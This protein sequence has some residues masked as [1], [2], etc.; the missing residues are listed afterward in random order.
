MSSK[1]NTMMMGNNSASDTSNQGT[2]GILKQNA[3]G[4]GIKLEKGGAKNII[5]FKVPSLKNHAL[6]SSPGD[7]DHFSLFPHP[8]NRLNT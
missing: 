6:M 8:A 3:S 1:Y 7:E 4:S 5:N 2:S